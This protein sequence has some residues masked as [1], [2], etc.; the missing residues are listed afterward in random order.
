MTSGEK[1]LSIYACYGQTL[2]TVA[3]SCITCPN[4]SNPLIVLT[5][6]SDSDNANGYDN[7][8]GKSTALEVDRH[9]LS[10]HNLLMYNWSWPVQFPP[11]QKIMK[12]SIIFRKETNYLM[13]KTKKSRVA[14]RILCNIQTLHWHVYT[15]PLWE[16]ECVSKWA[17]FQTSVASRLASLVSTKLILTTITK[18]SAFIL[19]KL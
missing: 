10:G 8:N 14:L 15:F 17:E 19:V 6:L 12:M 11:H 13:V 7:A 5:S 9:V 4:L 16:S 2:C 3:H 1:H 18:P